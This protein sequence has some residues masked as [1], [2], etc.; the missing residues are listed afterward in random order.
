MQ[1]RHVTA[2]E[3]QGSLFSVLTGISSALWVWDSPSQSFIL[4]GCSPNRKCS[5]IVDGKDDA[6][7]DSVLSRFLRIGSSIRRLETC[8]DRLRNKYGKISNF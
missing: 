7:S 8:V 2:S 5:I 1:V 4:G 3:L 6:V